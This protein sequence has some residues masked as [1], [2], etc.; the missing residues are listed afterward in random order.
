MASQGLLSRALSAA[1]ALAFA[2]SATSASADNVD[3][4][5][6]VKLRRVTVATADDLLGQ[7][8]EDGKTL[9]FLTNRDTT[10]Q[11]FA[12]NMADGHAWVLFDDGAD[13]TW[14]RVSPDGKLL[15]YISFRESASGQLCIRRLPQGDGR[16]CL[17]GPAA[18]QAEWIDARRIVVV[19]RQSVQEDLRILEVTLGPTL[20]TR[21]LVDR[22][23]TSP[24]VS[25]DGQWLVYVPV[26][27]SVQAV[28]PSFAAHAAQELEAVPLASVATATP[29]KIALELPGQTGQPVFARDGRSLYVV[30]FFTDT[31]HDG[32]VDAGD[33]GVLFRVPITFSGGAP[34][35]G[36]PEQL[37]ETSWN[38]E[39][40]SPQPDRLVATCAQEGDTLD[41]YSMPLDGEVPASWTTQMLHNAI[42]DADTLVVEQL[43]TS[44]LLARETTPAA[45]RKAMLSLAMVHLQ[46]AEFR[47][48]EFYA[49]KIHEL[50]DAST[51]GI[52]LPLR[53]IVEERR[54][55]RRRE[56]GRLFE[57]FSA[58][59]HARLERLRTDKYES[60]MAEDLTHLARSEI[61]GG[62]GDIGKARSELEAVTPDET[63]PPPIVEAYFKD[64][65][66][67]YRQ[68]DDRDALVKVGREL[69]AI[70]GL[71]PDQQ[72]RYARVTVR[73]LVRGLPYA[74]ADARLA[75][76]QATLTA[77]E[78]ELAFALDLTKRVLAIRDAHAPASVGEAL[79]TL[80]AAQTR[81]GRRRALVV[82]AVQRADEVDADNVLDALTQ[83]DIQSVNRGTHERG[84]A[85][86]VYERL[87]LARA[88]E[89]AN[90][91]QSGDAAQDFDSVAEQTGSLEAVVGSINM[92]LRMKEAPEA[93]VARYAAPGT[94]Q[95]RA[96][97]AKAYVLARQ[98]PTLE[99]AAHAKAATEA[100][101]ALEASWG[102]LKEERM[103]Q[104][105]FGALLHEEYLQTN[106]LATAERANVHYLVALELMGDNPRFRAMI[107][108]ELGLLHTDVGNYRIALGYLLERDKLPYADNTEGL[109]V[110]LS[111]AQALIHVGKDGD[112]AAA[113]EAALEMIKRKPALAPF[114]LLAL[115]WAALD[116]LSANRAA[117][118]LALY[119]E[120]IP[121]VDQSK[122][123]LAE[124]NALVTRLARAA[125]AVGANQ[126]QRAL[127][128]IDYVEKR[129]DDPK[130]TAQLV[131]PH[132]Q[133]ESVTP[134]YRLITNGLRARAD[135]ALGQLEAEAKAIEARRAILDGRFKDLPSRVDLERDEM[136]AEAQLAWNAGERR[137]PVAAS[138]W[139]GLALTHAD[140][141]QA[142]AS[143]VSDREGLDVLWMAAVLA[144]SMKAPLV[145]DLPKRLEAA[146]AETTARREPALR[147]Y[148]R[149]FEVY[150]AI[151]ARGGPSP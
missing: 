141:L 53:M 11:V 29:R 9:Y 24:A 105:L 137:D 133:A 70:K 138:R 57:G 103:A 102:E 98:L 93:I 115:D 143:G 110:L 65:D 30:Q 99:G 82:D 8:G 135:R 60:P 139:L 34:V 35:A 13:V 48:A 72:L 22:N 75:R 130:V 112:A 25:P 128:D 62:L 121:M 23:L 116:N 83:R 77:Q 7:L 52:S 127:A 84:E 15:L 1:L 92:R 51:S 142:K 21:T 119:E 86:D 14:P 90:A 120:E 129:L 56:Q 145:A 58:E 149:W 76:E 67:F 55:E 109:D 113:A 104:A 31:N 59:A 111:K 46:K 87:I 4:D 26:A 136:L 6:L 140:D 10:N 101:A 88:Y 69:A 74:E 78:P 39:Y 71:P 40:P 80:Y 73:A 50:R 114:R 89:R 32:T 17:Q 144:T 68:V 47:P 16:Q 20:S 33:H 123:A 42:D 91:G 18:L 150:A 36:A 118:A 108:G 79:L 95:A 107:L 63:T 44:R 2:L 125:A 100:R 61:Y 38:C 134:V 66:A 124:R 43:L 12:Q 45:R 96:R 81:P 126:A 19:S 54:A 132:A 5:D 49:E 28:G 117:R 122:E 147:P 37:T 131:W 41:V 97:F 85:E 94:A 148:A 3:D 106:D 27:R 151:L 64:A 146:L